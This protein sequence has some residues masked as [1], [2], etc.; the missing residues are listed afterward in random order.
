MH[1]EINIIYIN[2]TVS[3]QSDSKCEQKLTTKN[4][5]RTVSATEV[6]MSYIRAC[7]WGEYKQIKWKRKFCIIYQ[8]STAEN[9]DCQREQTW[10]S[11]SYTL[12]L[13]DPTRACSSHCSE[14]RLHFQYP[15]SLQLDRNQGPIHANCGLE[16][17]SGCRM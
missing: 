10:T 4:F 3:I 2:K 15:L 1:R 13:Q 6:K 11:I 9:V 14:Q 16:D 17:T 12:Q 8:H 5:Q 7:Y